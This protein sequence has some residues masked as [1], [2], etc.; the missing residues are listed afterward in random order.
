MKKSKLLTLLSS[1]SKEEMKNFEK[2]IES[3]YFNKERNFKPLYNILKRHHPAFDSTLFTEERIFKKLYPGKVYDRRSSVSLRVI[4]S[5]LTNLAEKFL[6]YNG[7]ETGKYVFEYNKCLTKTYID[8]KLLDPALK[9]ALQNSK[10]IDEDLSKENHYNRRLEM[11]SLFSTIFIQQLKPVENFKHTSK[12][13]LYLYSGFIDR[14]TEFYAKFRTNM[15]NY[16]LI[17]KGD[18]LVMHFVKTFDPDLF[19]EE[20]DDDEFETKKLALINYY[21]LKSH[22]DEL[23]KDSLMIALNIYFDIFDRL[24]RYKQFHLFILLFSRCTERIIHDS[25]YIN[26]GN[27]LID[28]VWG[29]VL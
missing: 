29:K 3:P 8:K 18:K 24:T 1:F 15:R 5:Q 20:C 16:N 21:F 19:E 4:E 28:T 13:I 27:E 11:Y 26:A 2:F 23:D 10:I 6:V 7:F 17:Y 25:Y 14:F 22:L 12:S 9:V